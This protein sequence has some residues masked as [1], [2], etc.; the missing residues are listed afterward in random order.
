MRFLF[1]LLLG[2]FAVQKAFSFVTSNLPVVALNTR[3]NWVLF[4]KSLP[5]PMSRPIAHVSSSSFHALGSAMSSLIHLDLVIVPGDRYR[6]N[7]IF[8]HMDI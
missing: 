2:S 1:T 8:L 4:G 7:F 3:G 5:A 6:S